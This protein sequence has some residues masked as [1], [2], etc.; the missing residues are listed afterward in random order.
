MTTK[1]KRFSGVL[2]S[3]DETNPVAVAPAPL[4]TALKYRGFSKALDMV[5]H[6]EYNQ[7]LAEL[8]EA[9]GITS[10]SGLH[11]YRY[12]TVRLRADQAAKVQEVFNRRGIAQPWDA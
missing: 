7:V 5:P 1:Q 3:T 11:A 6:G 4:T 9:L 12:G 2:P 10:R 8:R